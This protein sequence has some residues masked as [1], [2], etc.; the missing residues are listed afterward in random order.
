MNKLPKT[1]SKRGFD[2][3]L[4][5]RVEDVAIYRLRRN[6]I[7]HLEVFRILSHDGISI[8]GKSIPASEYVPSDKQWGTYGFSYRCQ[9]RAE[10]K[11][12]EL[13]AK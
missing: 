7:D 13:L 10:N 2:Y 11:F 9:K 12:H 1:F 5:N 8:A 6:G 4:I 3:E